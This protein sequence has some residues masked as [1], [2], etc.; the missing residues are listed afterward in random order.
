M[1]AHGT[2]ATMTAVDVRA[3]KSAFQPKRDV[4]GYFGH[5]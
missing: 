3:L 2:N 5:T 1:S 4:G